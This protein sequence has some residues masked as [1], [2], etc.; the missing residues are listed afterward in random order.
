MSTLPIMQ[1]M[2]ELKNILAASSSAVL[3]AEPG[4]GKTTMTPLALLDEP[5]MKGKTMLMLEPRRLAARAAAAYMASCLGEQAGQTV[6]YRMRMDSRTGPNTRIIV[7]TEGVLTRM[8]Q[9][10]P[11]LGDTGLVI[12]DE[13]H[14]RSLNADLGLALS[15]ETQAVL[16]ED[17]KILVMSATLD[18]EKVSALLGGAPVVRCPGRVFPV[19]TVYAPPA[20]ATPLEKAAGNAVRRALAEEPGDILLFLPGEREIRRT[21]S[22]LRSGALPGNVA[23]RPLYGQLPQAEQDSAVAPAAQGQRKV[24]L[25]TS[26]AETSLTIEGVRTVIDSGLRRTQRFSPRTG[27]PRLETLPISKASADQRRG[28][29]G[30]T[31]PG[32]C[33]RLW[34]REEHDRLPESDAPEILEA[35]LAGLALELALWGVR[36]PAQLAWLDAPPPAP[37]AQA[38]ALLRQLGALDAAGAITPHGR[39]LAALGT[40]PRA[41]HMLLRAAGLGAA[42]LACRLAALLQER[43]PLRGPV[44]GSCDLTLR[45]EALLRYEAS[46]GRD[47]GGGDPA[48]L[49]AAAR[50]SRALEAQLRAAAPERGLSAAEEPADA[51]LSGLLLSFAYPDRIG[52]RRGGGAFLLSG[53]RGAAM[54]ESQHLAREPYIVAVSVDD[55]GT[56]SRIMLA[57]AVDERDLLEHHADIVSELAEVYWDDESKSVKSRHRTMLGE[58]TLK[59]SGHERPSPEEAARVLMQVIF[60]EGLRLLPWDKGTLQLRERLAFMHRLDPAWPDVSDDGLSGSMEEWLLPYLHGCRSLRDVQRLPLREALDSMLDWER[61]RRLDQEAPTHIAVPS[62]SRI[63]VDY[64]DPA[65]PVLAVKLQEMFGQR[66]TPRIG[67]GRVPVLLHLLSPARRPVQVTAD[68]ASFWNNTY[69]EVKKDLKGR[70]PKH[71]WPEDP[72]QAIPTHRTRPVK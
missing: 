72:L 44:S 2:P 34:S 31:A 57:A 41:A 46:A 71:Y 52:Q 33:Y 54:G 11:S 61:K 7:V 36:D 4:A 68:L 14:E 28:R 35:D 69:F 67:A 22:E 60:G 58:L 17:L 16:R 15:L 21:E 49:R 66:E 53:G 55:K 38:T 12:F 8:L 45:V 48:A 63:A 40:H 27:M 24:V 23:L 5:W 50:A 13:F 26:I 62:G 3:I 32:V 6:G 51:S 70:Y 20:A 30:R 19:E 29:A 56:Q 10:D 39:R 1:I 65:A 59:E 25:A 9:D 64:S 47:A 43:D 42:P 37:Y 18:G